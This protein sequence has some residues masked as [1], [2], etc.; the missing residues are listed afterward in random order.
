MVQAVMLV[1]D[2]I[3]VRKAYVKGISKSALSRYVLK[4][5]I[6]LTAVLTSKYT[7][8]DF[9]AGTTAVIGKVS[10]HMLTNVPWFDTKESEMF[11]V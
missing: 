6:D 7:Q 9:H 1:R 4:Y 3:P 8:S 11:S 5:R 2:G 10:N